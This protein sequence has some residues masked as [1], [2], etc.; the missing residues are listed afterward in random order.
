MGV[1]DP[2][3]WA[4]AAFPRPFPGI[5]INSGAGRV[6]TGPGL[7]AGI[8]GSRLA[9]ITARLANIDTVLNYA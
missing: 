3:L 2:T 5:W 6:L 1:M 4:S 7:D 8:P 9:C